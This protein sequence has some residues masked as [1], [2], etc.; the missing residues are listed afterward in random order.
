[1][2]P[3]FPHHYNFYMYDVLPPLLW[4]VLAARLREQWQQLVGV[5]QGEQR[6]SFLL[7]S[8]QR[9]PSFFPSLNNLVG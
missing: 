8:R 3:Y 2:C 4:S 9:R 6:G 1:M 5:T 7:P